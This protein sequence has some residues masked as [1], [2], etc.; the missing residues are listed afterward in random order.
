ME[1]GA[2]MDQLKEIIIETL[3][4]ISEEIPL[5]RNLSNETSYV[6]LDYASLKEELT[7]IRGKG[8]KYQ[9]LEEILPKYTSNPYTKRR[10]TYYIEKGLLPEP[11]KTTHNQA[12]YTDKH[13]GLFLLVDHMQ[14]YI[15]LDRIKNYFDSIGNSLEL[16]HIEDVISFFKEK[17]TEPRKIEKLLSMLTERDLESI[18]KYMF[19][20][21][22]YEKYELSYIDHQLKVTLSMIL[23]AY[24]MSFLDLF[25]K[26]FKEVKE[27]QLIQ[28]KMG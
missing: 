21:M 24:G 26:L 25:D 23:L 12:E 1:E 22:D 15:G 9:Y 28:L 8:I 5:D 16:A 18:Q 20:N 11:H 13:I 27:E 6:S 2:C 3:K 10:L 19:A 14:S 17:L 7:Q 4:R